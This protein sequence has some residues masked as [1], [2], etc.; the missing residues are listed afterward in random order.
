MPSAAASAVLAKLHRLAVEQDLALRR[1]LDA[2][3][4]LHQRRFAGAVLA[5]QH[6]DG[7]GPHFEV[8]VLDRHRAGIDLGDA[9]TAGCRRCSALAHGWSSLTSA[10]VIRTASVAVVSVK[11]PEQLDLL[12]SSSS[13]GRLSSTVA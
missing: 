6:V 10:G 3:D 13:R 1:L 11:A 4:D 7:A 9:A 8:D 2:G 5:D 12:P